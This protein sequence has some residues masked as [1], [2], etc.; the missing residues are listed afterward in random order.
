MSVVGATGG[1]LAPGLSYFDLEFLGIARAQAAAVIS[2]PGRVAV[3]D[4][5]PSTTLERL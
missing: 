1:V 2:A 5:G 4:P 3:V